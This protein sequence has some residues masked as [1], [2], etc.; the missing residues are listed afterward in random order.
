MNRR[1]RA[2]SSASIR[3][4]DRIVAPNAAIEKAMI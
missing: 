1:R 3:H 4:Q 2:I